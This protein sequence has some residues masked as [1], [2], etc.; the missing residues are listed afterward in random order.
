MVADVKMTSKSMLDCISKAMAE[1]NSTIL[2]LSEFIK[3]RKVSDFRILKNSHELS[4]IVLPLSTLLLKI[5]YEMGNL[6]IS[7]L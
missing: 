5:L 7:F 4:G 2:I 6:A 3:L 1:F